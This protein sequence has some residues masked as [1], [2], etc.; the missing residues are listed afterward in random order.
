MN[1]LL[2]VPTRGYVWHETAKQLEPYNPQYVRTKLSVADG[3]NRIVKE[4]LKTNAEVLVMCDDD[5]IP[6]PEFLDVLLRDLELGGFEIIGASV[7]VGKFPKHELFINA[8]TLTPS[9]Q[10]ET[11]VLTK[12]STLRVDAIGTGLCAI[13]RAVFEHPSM[14]AP[15][16]QGIDE[17]GLIVVGQD[18]EFCRRARE[19]GFSI[20]V[21]TNIVADHFVS[22]H[23]NAIHTA[24]RG[25]L[26]YKE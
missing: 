26:S 14:K 22:A 21:T 5:V 19:S 7:P 17:D 25:D 8:F 2:A 1:V 23:A 18:L 10:Y 3:R 4:F 9:G 15:F 16:Q 6:P 24:Y 13:K 20:G 12:D 11:V